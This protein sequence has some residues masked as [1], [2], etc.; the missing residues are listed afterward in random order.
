MVE[1]RLHGELAR[2]FGKVWN[3]A[4]ETPREA[5]EAINA[6][7]PGFKRKIADLARR[8]MVFRV[9]TKQ[10]DY[11]NED[12]GSTLGNASRLDIVPIVMGASAGIRFVVGAVLL[13]VGLYTVN[14]TL[15]T[16]GASLMLGSIVEWLT[17][18]PKAKDGVNKS[19]SWTFNGPLNT[20]EQGLPV[21]I[22]YGEVLT[23]AYPISA[24]I[25]TSSINA[26]SSAASATV[27]GQTSAH[28]PMTTLTG[29][30][31]GVFNLSSAAINID[32]P[33]T[34]AWSRSGF[35]G[36][37]AVNMAPTDK[38]STKLSITLNSLGASP[39]QTVSG[40]VTLTV[41]GK[42]PGKSTTATATVSQTITAYFDNY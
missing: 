18:V 40:T 31:T 29:P 32:E 1:V 13:A 2:E 38:A 17:P 3:L 15:T 7:M 19:T 10:H 35:A 23:G 22:I 4:I 28:F 5:I 41:T 42:R 36:A 8:G 14:P 21:P 12:V 30:V 33:R 37:S 11:D 34:Y 6:N 27:S 25:A 26:D 24:G 16:M 9:R 20:V 39:S